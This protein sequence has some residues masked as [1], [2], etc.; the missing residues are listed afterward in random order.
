[1]MFGYTLRS[2][3]LEMTVAVAVFGMVAVKVRMNDIFPSRGE[4]VATS[5][6]DGPEIS[7]S[8]HVRFV[9][10]RSIFYF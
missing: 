4:A 5:H 8:W 9:D 3:I 6:G 1:M 10:T 2:A 7:A